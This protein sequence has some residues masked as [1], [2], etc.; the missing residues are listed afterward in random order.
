MS[1]RDAVTIIVYA[2]PVAQTVQFGELTCPSGELVIIDPGELYLWS[3]DDAPD[4]A[5]FGLG[6]LIDLEIVGPDADAAA[7]AFDQQPGAT[8]YDTPVEHLD[9]LTAEFDQLCRRRRLRAA[10]QPLP[11]TSHRERVRRVAAEGGGEFPFV[12]VSAVGIGGVPV[13]R[14]LPVTAVRI[15][16]GEP[17]GENW[18]SF[19]V[20]FGPA[21]V[22]GTRL[23]GAVAV[24]NARVMFADAD[25]LSAWRHEQASDGRADVAFWG[26]H[27]SEAAQAFSAPW[28]GRAGE[29]G[30]RGWIDLPVADAYAQA[31]AIEQ[32]RA[33]HNARLMVDFRPHSDHFALMAQVRA[34]PFG[35]GQV[36]VGGAQLVG[37]STGFG[38]GHYEV[39]LELDDHQQPAGV[40]LLFATPE[41][42]EQ[43]AEF[44]EEYG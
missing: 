10:L 9:E 3:G 24:D 26:L 29:D 33:E 7:R 1:N 37:A 6:E 19:R 5:L 16:F 44:V 28:L 38:D 22:T 31:C 27:E 35:A 17:V 43:F 14:P 23:L 41:N 32:W 13:D 8:L 39:H 21:H 42:L 2:A 11:R 18:H 25:A 40:Q 20:A 4:D 15:D 12:G 30:V 36:R 34:D